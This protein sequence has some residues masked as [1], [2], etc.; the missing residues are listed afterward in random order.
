MNLIQQQQTPQHRYVDIDGPEESSL[1][2][3]QYHIDHDSPKSDIP[4]SSRTNGD[5]RYIESPI[6]IISN[7][8]QLPQFTVALHRFKA[9][10]SL[11]KAIEVETQ[12]KDFTCISRQQGQLLLL[13]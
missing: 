3:S 13:R 9:V 2:T 4:S 10:Q 6:K 11:L 7:N 12:Q 5:Y 8:N 1:V